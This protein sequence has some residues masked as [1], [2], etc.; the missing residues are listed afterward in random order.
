MKTQGTDAFG[1]GSNLDM[2]QMPDWSHPLMAENMLYNRQL[3]A[4][5]KEVIGE[6]GD[7]DMSKLVGPM[8]VPPDL[9]IAALAATPVAT[10]LSL[11]NPA[12]ATAGAGAPAAANPQG[13]AAAAPAAPAVNGARSLGSS[14]AVVALVA[15]FATVFAL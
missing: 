3:F 1:W 8:S 15:V 7:I 4:A 11:A 12:A 10:T 9:N 5:N 14:S 6:N 13:A 2:A